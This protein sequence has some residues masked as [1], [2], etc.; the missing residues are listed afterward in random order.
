MMLM[1]IDT[2]AAGFLSASQQSFSRL[3]T[4][5]VGLYNSYCSKKAFGHPRFSA[6]SIP[7]KTVMMEKGFCGRISE[8]AMVWA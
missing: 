7:I 6:L 3:Y 1:L 5:F 4:P 8:T 2:M